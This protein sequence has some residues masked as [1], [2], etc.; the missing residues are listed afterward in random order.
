MS[1]PDPEKH[2]SLHILNSIYFSYASL[3]LAFTKE[4]KEIYKDLE[5]CTHT[6][7]AGSNVF[8]AW[9]CIAEKTN[10]FPAQ[11]NSF[12][13]RKEQVFRE[14]FELL[15]GEHNLIAVTLCENHIKV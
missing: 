7:F 12:I 14:Q 11:L 3:F 5:K 8:Q 4:N 6:W 1:C 13:W 9:S 2:K 10:H 15:K